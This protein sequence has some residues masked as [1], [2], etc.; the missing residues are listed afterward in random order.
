VKKRQAGRIGKIFEKWCNEQIEEAGLGRA[1]RT[2]GSGSGKIKGDSF[3]S[4]DFMFE[5]KSQRAPSYKGNIKQAKEQA[6]KGNSYKD[7]WVLVQ[8]DPETPQDNPQAFAILDYHEFLKLLKKDKEPMVKEPDREF[9]WRLK[10]A[11]TALKALEKY[12]PD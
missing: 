10:S 9:K 2:P 4:L 3:N 1:I 11:V 8:R 6:I 7:K 12:L 5:F